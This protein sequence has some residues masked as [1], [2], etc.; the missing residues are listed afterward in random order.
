MA[1]RNLRPKIGDK[2]N[3][4]QNLLD[5]GYISS[6]VAKSGVDFQ[7]YYNERLVD[8]LIPLID[9]GC[10]GELM[11]TWVTENNYVNVQFSNDRKCKILHEN[12][13]TKDILLQEDTGDRLFNY[14]VSILR[15]IKN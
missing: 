11:F 13:K 12:L 7:N 15:K 3:D 5:L 4:I 1:L 8:L 14:I 9:V 2:M 10:D 6:H